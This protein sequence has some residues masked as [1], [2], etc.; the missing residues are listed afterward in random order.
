MKK[1]Q[2]I[3]HTHWD[4]EWYF[5]TMDSLVL[6]DGI[7]TEIIDELKSNENMFFTLDGQISILEEF[8]ELYPEKKSD[9]RYLVEKNQ[10]FIGPWYTQTDAQL[11]NGESIIRNLL[12]GMYE[13]KKIAKP[14]KVG[15][16]PDTFGFNAQ[17][18]TILLNSGINNIVFWRGIDYDKVK[19]PYFI[20]QG[21]SN[22]K[23]LAINLPNG[24]GSIPRLYKDKEFLERKVFAQEKLI[25]EK[26]QLDEILIPIGNDQNKITNNINEILDEINKNHDSEYVSSNYVKFIEY[27]SKYKDCLDMYKG[28]F[29][30]PITGRV[31]K[32]IGSIRCDI[33][34]Y[35]FKLEEILIKRIEP[36]FVLCNSL[37]IKISKNLLIKAWKKLL[38]GQAHD[39]IAGCV[40]DAVAVDI[41][42]RMKQVDELCVSI[43]N[44]LKK[45]IADELDLQDD[46]IILFN[47]EGKPFKGYKDIL[48][49]TKYPAIKIKDCINY[50]N[51]SVKKCPERKNVLVEGLYEN[52]YTTEDVYYE[53][54][55]KVE[56]ELPAFGYQVF[57]IEEDI[58][59]VNNVDN[60]LDISNEK[61]HIWV[62]EN[63][64]NLAV[65]NLVIEDF[66]V[67][68]DMG[69]DGDTYDFSPLRNDK[70]LYFRL[71]KGSRVINKIE[72][73]LILVGTIML[74]KTLLDRLDNNYKTAFSIT[75]EITLKK[76]EEA[77]EF[78][79]NL[80]NT[81]DSH[82][83]RVILKTNIK[84]NKSI[85]SIPFGFLERDILNK[86]P[87][88]WEE[89][90]LENPIDIEVMN[91]CVAIK[92]EC[93]C[94]IVYTKGIKEYQVKE[95]KI[96]LTLFATT[97]ELG[98]S[99]L[100]YRPGRA[101]GDITKKGHVKINTPKAQVKGDLKF[102][103]M[104]DFVKS[105]SESEIVNKY[106]KYL[107]QSIYYQNQDFNKF[108]NR[109]DNKIQS[110]SLN[111]LV[112]KKY[113]LFNLEHLTISTIMPSLY[114]DDSY[115]IRIENKTNIKQKLDL[116]ELQNN[117]KIEFI[118]AVEDVIEPVDYI[119]NYDFVQIRI[120][121]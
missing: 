77:P 118:N 109:I 119:D 75:L 71:I 34:Q 32:T 80:N 116:N 59:K 88:G 100:L 18:P 46:E 56:V 89:K 105:F 91:D 101:S 114:F 55:L 102:E 83:L 65:N 19:S 17:M 41:L 82:R 94:A 20:W 117:F 108:L 62:N 103:F 78:V 6:S 43:E 98:K 50:C 104:L 66:I 97:G 51:Y 11:I 74:P 25:R 33:K 107:S 38:E 64:L 67:F 72:E 31:H 26:T 68:E 2:I 12:I 61:Y 81:V 57:K 92:D 58:S 40:S 79:V 5:S 24:Y 35:N 37:G 14:M 73:K 3:N 42:Q 30:T 87:D 36:L 10:L 49:L 22:K 29:R 44:L 16:L 99:D 1:V 113:S 28:E 48:V 27:L 121:R 47:L 54:K 70:P 86:E 63:K 8:L 15:Y 93:N 106:N 4:R 110:K 111:I 9:I 96:I 69:N 84:A 21:L 120:S 76:G 85:A 60:D 90:Y 53:H 112:P 115:V 39:S 13:T 95:D 52:F 23:I 7:F 45:R